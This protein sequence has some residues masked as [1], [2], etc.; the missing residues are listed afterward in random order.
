MRASSGASEMARTARAISDDS[1][2]G[3]LPV[4]TGPVREAHV[5]L[6]LDDALA[7]TFPASDPVAVDAPA[8][9]TG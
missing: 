5:E 6:A 2:P 9:R 7:A 1:T 3:A 8:E 4:P